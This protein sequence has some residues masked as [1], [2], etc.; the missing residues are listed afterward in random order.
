MLCECVWT[1]KLSKHLKM[2]NLNFSFARSTELNW[3]NNLTNVSILLNT[4]DK[5]FLWMTLV[6]NRSHVK[7][8][9]VLP[10]LKQMNLDA[11]DLN[12]FR[13]HVSYISHSVLKGMSVHTN[14]GRRFLVCI[15]RHVALWQVEA[16]GCVLLL[17]RQKVVW[18]LSPNL[19]V[20]C[21][22]KEQ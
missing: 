3:F 17:K 22:T 19:S 21:C 6:V 10:I 2:F 7:G 8:E 18:D 5:W 4:S 20:S 15:I 11:W 14:P 1:C 12:A 13:C 16:Q 9:E